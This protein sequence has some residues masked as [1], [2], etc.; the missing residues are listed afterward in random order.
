MEEQKSFKERVKETVIQNAYSYKRYF[1]D[2]EYL[3]CSVAF[4]KKLI[5]IFAREDRMKASSKVP[6]EEKSMHYHQLWI[7]L[8]QRNW[9]WYFVENQEKANLQ[10]C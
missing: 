8:R 4:V 5:L 6:L 9:T 10:K 1:V 2:Y 7:L 3:I